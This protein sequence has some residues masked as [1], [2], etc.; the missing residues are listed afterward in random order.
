[1]S[2]K[3]NT[4]SDTNSDTILDICILTAGRADLFEKCLDTL[5]PMMK[6]E[7]QLYVFNNGAPSPAYSELYKKFP[8]TVKQTNVNVG[9]P[10]GE[11]GRA[12]V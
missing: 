7:Y 8:M 2:R 1:M 5:I 3:N 12:H 10:A 6:P 9:Y 11:I 4:N